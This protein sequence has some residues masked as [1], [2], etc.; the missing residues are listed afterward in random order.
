MNSCSSII[1]ASENL[2]L[3]IFV[4]ME[5]PNI[6]TFSLKNQ[7]VPEIFLKLSYKLP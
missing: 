6:S 5:Q 4:L 2:R 3:Y 7:N 1:T